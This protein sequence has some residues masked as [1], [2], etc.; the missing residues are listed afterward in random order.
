MNGPLHWKFL[1]ALT[2]MG[3]FIA[4]I[5]FALDEDQALGARA[6]LGTIILAVLSAIS[7][8]FRRR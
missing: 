4:V 7:F 1:T 8:Y 5:H 3:Y 2:V 6:M